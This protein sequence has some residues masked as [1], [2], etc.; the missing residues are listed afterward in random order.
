MEKA[1][2]ARLATSAVN[3]PARMVHHCG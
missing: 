3:K 2:S 1:F